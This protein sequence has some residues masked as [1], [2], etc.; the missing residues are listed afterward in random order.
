MRLL[1]LMLCLSSPTGKDFS[2]LFVQETTVV[3]TTLFSE[4][5]FSCT[6]VLIVVYQN[7]VFRDCQLKFHLIAY[8]L[9][10][11]LLN[12]LHKLIIC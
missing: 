11:F 3:D 1:D 2:H 7:I 10:L 6:C 4:Q 12:S 8:W 5:F 9:R